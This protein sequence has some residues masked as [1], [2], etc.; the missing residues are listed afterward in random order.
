MIFDSDNGVI[1]ICEFFE[2]RIKLVKA[3]IGAWI[4]ILSKTVIHQDWA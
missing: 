2:M 4:F 3:D 1:T